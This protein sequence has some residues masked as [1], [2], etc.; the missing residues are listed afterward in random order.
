MTGD[1][2][3]QSARAAWELSADRDLPAEIAKWRLA[4]SLFASDELGRPLARQAADA[5]AQWTPERRE[6]DRTPPF[7]VQ[8]LAEFLDK[9]GA[10]LS[11]AEI[12]HTL[13]R[14]RD[15]ND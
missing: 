9:A 10:P 2:G 11:V 1:R 12:V 7:E 3:C 8:V 13:D 14:R 6:A 5:L 4:L 15:Q